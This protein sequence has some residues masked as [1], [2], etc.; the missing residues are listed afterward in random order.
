MDDNRTAQASNVLRFPGRKGSQPGEGRPTTESIAKASTPVTG[1]RNAQMAL[2]A[3]ALMA[4]A[5]NRFAFDRAEQ[6]VS[7]SSS[8]PGGRALASV[9]NLRANRD[10]KW[11]MAM[12]ERL[13][14][15]RSRS[16]A[17]MGIGRHP[18]KEEE[19]R[20][21]I[22]EQ[23]YTI[24]FHP[25]LGSIQTITLQGDSVDPSYLRNRP[26]FLENFGNLLDR[27]YES[28]K[29]KSVERLQDNRTVE[30]YTLFN[31]DKKAVVETQFEFD[32]FERLLSIKVLPIAI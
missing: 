30:A 28:A 5:V 23:K 3:I 20:Y 11:E 16:P 4:V 26:E 29:L 6:S 14:S 10:S 32:R 13:A 7:L 25:T 22:L 9:E 12:S 21:G 17:S 24:Q 19:L 2:V 15:E 1:R 31:A 8:S 18:T 27:S